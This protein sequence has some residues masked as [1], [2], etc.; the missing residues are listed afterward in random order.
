MADEIE[1]VDCLCL[2]SLARQI[3]IRLVLNDSG[4]TRFANTRSSKWTLRSRNSRFCQQS[5]GCRNVLFCVCFSI[6]SGSNGVSIEKIFASFSGSRFCDASDFR[7]PTQRFLLTLS[8]L[9]SHLNFVLVPVELYSNKRSWNNSLLLN[10][11]KN[12]PEN[13]RTSKYRFSEP[14]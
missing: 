13:G 3:S 11:N 5:D 14:T 2:S 12:V 1:A 10:K 7:N 4:V 9:F 8:R 6:T